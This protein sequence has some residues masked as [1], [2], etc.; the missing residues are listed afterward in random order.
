MV[1]IRLK[2]RTQHDDR[3]CDICEHMDGYEWVFEDTI[4]ESLMHPVYG[5]VWNSSIGSLTHERYQYGKKYGLLSS[6]RC[7]IE[8]VAVSDTKLLEELRALRD[9]LKDAL[10]ES[11]VDDL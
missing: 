10:T 9:L 5:E 4:P 1:Q 7:R 2:W 6:C 3:V 11:E 8:P